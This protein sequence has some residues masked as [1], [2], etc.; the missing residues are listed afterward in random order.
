MQEKKWDWRD[1]P[2]WATHVGIVPFESSEYLIWYNDLRYKYVEFV[3]T[4][5]PWAYGCLDKTKVVVVA[6]RQS[7]QENLWDGEGVPP[8][9][10]ICVARADGSTLHK[11]KV[12]CQPVGT[13]Q[14][15]EVV[16]V[17]GLE[18]ER[19]C[20]LWWTNDYQK[21][22][23]YQEIEAENEEK[24][25]VD[26]IYRHLV[27]QTELSDTPLGALLTTAKNLYEDGLRFIDKTN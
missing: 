4:P 9:G 19:K 21:I 16:A 11:V 1:S 7:E 18:G 23:T 13:E 5:Y 2:E 10:T 22:K 12:I 8:N 15:E 14:Q 26:L 20:L 3:D 25:Q 27:R 17:V 24:C 6:T